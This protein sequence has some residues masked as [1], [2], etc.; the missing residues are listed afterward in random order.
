MPLVKFMSMSKDGRLNVVQRCRIL[1]IQQWG[2]SSLQS[3]LGM[4]QHVFQ[5]FA[6]VTV[7]FDC[8]QV[9]PLQYKRV[10]KSINMCQCLCLNF[11]ELTFVTKMAILLCT[12]INVLVKPWSYFG[13]E[14]W[15]A[16]KCFENFGGTCCLRL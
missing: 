11:C 16:I 5:P 13:S 6:P 9:S 2:L 8:S 3:L 7:A 1:N 12:F 4:H 10:S 14:C 15:V